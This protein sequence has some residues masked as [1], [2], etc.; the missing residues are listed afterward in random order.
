MRSGTPNCASPRLH[1]AFSG[2]RS[3]EL[4][5]ADYQARRD[6]QVLPM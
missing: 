5:M 2:V 1:E 3:F 6:T 4:A